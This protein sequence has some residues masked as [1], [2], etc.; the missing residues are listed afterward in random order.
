[1]RAGGVGEGGEEGRG[2][3]GH[4]GEGG[5]RGVEEGAGVDDLADVG[6][7]DV[8]VGRGG[9]DDV[10]AAGGEGENGGFEINFVEHFAVVVVPKIEMGFFPKWI[11]IFF[12]NESDNI[13]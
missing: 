1:M 6:G 4:R 9:G 5:G 12:G 3:G 2:L 10:L 13:G 11:G 8:D 7:V